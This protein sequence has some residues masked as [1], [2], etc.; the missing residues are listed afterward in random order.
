GAVY[1]TEAAANGTTGQAYISGNSVTASAEAQG[2][3]VFATG[4]KLTGGAIASNNSAESTGADASGGFAYFPGA[5]TLAFGSEA[6]VANNT[7]KAGNDARGGAVYAGGDLNLSGGAISMTG[8]KADAKDTYAQ[9]GALYSGGAVTINAGNVAFKDNSVTSKKVAQGGA[10]YATSGV[11]ITATRAKF[12]SATDTVMAENGSITVK[13][14][15]EAGKGVSFRA[16]NGNI[17][18]SDGQFEPYDVKNPAANSGELPQFYASS[19]KF[20]LSG[21][22]LALQNALPAWADVDQRYKHDFAFV[23]ANEINVPDSIASDYRHNKIT[24]RDDFGGTVLTLEFGID[25]LTWYNDDDSWDVADTRGLWINSAGTPDDFYQSDHVTFAPTAGS[26]RV[27]IELKKDIVAGSVTVEGSYAFSGSELTT[28]PLAFTA[29]D[30]ELGM[31]TTADEAKLSAGSLTLSA[32]LIVKSAFTQASGAKLTVAAS[33][34]FAILNGFSTAALDAAGAALNVF[35]IGALANGETRTFKVAE[36]FASLKT[37]TNLEHDATGLRVEYQPDTDNATYYNLTFTSLGNIPLIWNGGSGAWA[38]ND[39]HQRWLRASDGTTKDDFYN[40]DSAIFPENGAAQ[41]VSL[42]G[43]LTA[44]EMTVKG[45]YAFAGSGALAVEKLSFEKGASTLNA[46]VTAEK[47]TL[48]DG[49]LTLEAPL[50]VKDLFR[51]TGG[52]LTLPAATAETTALLDGSGTAVLNAPAGT[53]FVKGIGALANG[54]TRTYKVATG[55]ASLN[56]W[57]DSALKGDAAGLRVEYAG[58][59]S[60]TA[61]DVTVTA[62]GNIPLIWNGGADTW[63]EN[64]GN[65]LWLRASDGVTKDDFYNGDSAIFPGNA[66]AE[67]VSLSGALTADEMTVN[68]DYVFTGSGTLSAGTLNVA[69]GQS[70]FAREITAGKGI[71]SGSGTVL[72][73]AAPLTVTDSFEQKS[74]ATLIFD[75][76]AFTG[77]APLLGENS[78]TLTV[79]SGAKLYLQNAKA[80]Y[81]GQQYPVALN[82]KA[83][84]GVWKNADVSGTAVGPDISYSVKTSGGSVIVTVTREIPVVPI[85]F[86]LTAGQSLRNASGVG[87]QLQDRGAGLANAPAGVMSAALGF[88]PM[89]QGKRGG[90]WASTWYTHARVDNDSADMTFKNYGVTIGAD[91]ALKNGAVAGLAVSLGKTEGR[92]KGEYTGSDSDGKHI[93]VSLYGAKNLADGKLT[94]AGDLGYHWHKDDYDCSGADLCSARNARSRVFTAGATAW[95]NLRRAGKVGVKPFLGLRYS[96]F[97]MDDITARKNGSDWSVIAGE[98]VAQWTVPLGVKFD[99]TPVTTKKGWKIRPSAELAYVYAGGD[100]AIGLRET[101]ISDGSPSRST[102]MLTD[103][104]N[105]RASLGLDAKRKDFTLGVGVNALLS[106]G[107]KDVSVNATLRWDL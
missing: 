73:L 35:G 77:T 27:K 71:L 37:W 54:E 14:S 20:D 51:Q 3:A 33:E 82:F 104:N 55:F 78:A 96:R 90:V 107:Q 24:M 13:G 38:V 40:G 97:S 103:R 31:V 86:I 83:V 69:A 28:G 19:G 101:K 1:A 12:L 36:A 29:G 11:T 7:S 42:T 92:G 46:A 75:V 60:A 32:P 25:N 50:T 57:H 26:K 95:W 9:G 80:S 16:D 79:T 49:S 53:L 59:K 47:A 74:G 18:V 21:S 102:Q 5:A 100:R 65:L 81:D 4:L 85:P 63:K 94:L 43:A 88:L 67:T 68:G 45:S 23:V 41:T 10:I 52:Q 72:T 2:G 17:T 15:L 64:D 44:E 84:A 93:G 91:K 6:L 48:E 98:S 39:G 99:W 22:K 34:T 105:F 30:S 89:E 70:R 66:A 58:A 87:T 62:L 56:P 106:S 61:Y 76:N 8:N